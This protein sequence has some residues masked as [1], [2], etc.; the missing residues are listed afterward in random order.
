MVTGETVM[1]ICNKCNET[2]DYCDCIPQKYRERIARE[3][4]DLLCTRDGWARCPSANEEH[5][6]TI[7]EV[8]KA[9]RG[10]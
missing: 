8:T 9:I 7:R 4:E 10:E 1:G 5:C 2:V 6:D 3:I